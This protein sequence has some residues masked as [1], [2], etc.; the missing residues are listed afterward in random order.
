MDASRN[1]GKITQVAK[2]S[3]PT[4]LKFSSA[5]LTGY[6]HALPIYL[7]FVSERNFSKGNRSLREMAQAARAAELQCLSIQCD[8]S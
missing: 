5:F 8:Q 3:Y 7:Q 2:V 4:T 6:E 1:A